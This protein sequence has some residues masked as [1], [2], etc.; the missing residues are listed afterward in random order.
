MK[1]RDR[2]IAKLRE[3]D[4]RVEKDKAEFHA[5][6]KDITN[7]HIDA[8]DESQ[9]RDND[10]NYGVKLYKGK[11]VFEF[12]VEEGQIIIP[13][14]GN[15]DAE[16]FPEQERERALDRMAELMAR[17]MRDPDFDRTEGPRATRV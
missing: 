17:A 13:A 4:D 5:L 6:Y 16:R 12:T 11:T 9:S 2:L 10:R 15:R 7:L 3:F 14:A 1:W 8:N